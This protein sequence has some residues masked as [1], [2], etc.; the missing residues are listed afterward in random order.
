MAFNVL[1][2][3]LSLLGSQKKDEENPHIMTPEN[4]AA[5]KSDFAPTPTPT[6]MAQA[7]TPGMW[8]GGFDQGGGAQVPYRDGMSPAGMGLDEG[9]DM[10]ERA[11]S[12][13]LMAGNAILNAL[14]GM[15]D[16]TQN[17]QFPMRPQSN[18]QSAQ[19]PGYVGLD[20]ILRQIAMGGRF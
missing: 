3:V 8:G 10:G 16:Y 2:L 4:A 18:Y 1:G 11:K 13:A 14:G 7:P 17:M 9:S 15:N 12:G 5:W 6:P 19:N 20:E